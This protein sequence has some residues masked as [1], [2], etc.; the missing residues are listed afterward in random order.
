MAVAEN[1]NQGETEVTET[2]TLETIIALQ[3]QN[4]EE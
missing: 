1:S 2:V 3:I 4:A